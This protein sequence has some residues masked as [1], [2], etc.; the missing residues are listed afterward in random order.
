MVRGI[1]YA[2]FGGDMML[3]LLKG[4]REASSVS[5]LCHWETELPVWTFQAKVLLEIFLIA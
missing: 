3:I 4:Q 5:L 1:I 2:D